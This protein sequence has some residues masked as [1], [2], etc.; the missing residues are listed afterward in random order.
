MA[1]LQKS[2]CLIPYDPA[3]VK[4]TRDLLSVSQNIFAP[5][6]GVSV[7]AVQAW[8]RGT[9]TPSHMASR[10]MDEIRHNPLYWRKRL[11]E[12]ISQKVEDPEQMESV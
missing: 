7:N 2:G 12:S 1:N 9:N 4:K 5:F 3:L 6:L 11:M 10:F 8:E